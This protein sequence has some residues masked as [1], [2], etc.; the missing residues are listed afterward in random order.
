M[1]PRSVSS[2]PADLS[3]IPEVHDDLAY[4]H[5][6][7]VAPQQSFAGNF[8]LGVSCGVEGGIQAANWGGGS[9]RSVGH[10]AYALPQPTRIPQAGA[11]TAGVAA[12]PHPFTIITKGGSGSGSPSAPVIPV[13]KKAA[14]PRKTREE[15]D[16]HVVSLIR[17][18]FYQCST[19]NPYYIYSCVCT[20]SK[21]SNLL[22]HGHMCVTDIRY[23]GQMHR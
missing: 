3:A 11:V 21:L 22:V 16:R 12:A 23:P 13:K 19:N 2:T 1:E 17:L 4:R 6:A 5:T 10:Q 7:S 20:G 14:P 15:Q 8:N 9:P 18:L